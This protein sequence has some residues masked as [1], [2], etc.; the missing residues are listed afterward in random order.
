MDLNA[1]VCLQKYSN[2]FGNKSCSKSSQSFIIIGNGFPELILVMSS[3]IPVGEKFYISVLMVKF[4]N[5]KLY[6]LT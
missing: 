6:C 2:S 3:V 5:K 1:W 4:A